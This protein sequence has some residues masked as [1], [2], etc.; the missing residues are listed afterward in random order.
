M[1]TFTQLR[2]GLA[3]NLAT[4]SGLR[5][6]NLIP[7]QVNP[8]I[9]IITPETITYDTSFAR[10]LDEYNFTILVVVHRVAERSAQ[11]SLDAFCNPTGSTSIKTAIESD[12]SLGG[13][14]QT[15]RVTNLRTYQALSVGDVDYLAAEFS[16]VV[17][18]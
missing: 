11:S 14:A 7:D 4:I 5:T 12:R 1:P 18:A 13:T 10:G 16:V 9:A 2:T 6:A 8:P 3:T 15:L 17:Y